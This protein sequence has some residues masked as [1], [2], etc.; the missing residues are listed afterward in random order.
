MLITALLIKLDLHGP[1]LFFHICNGFNG[2][3]FRIVKFRTMHV[4]ED[5]TSFAKRPAPTPG[6]PGSDDGYAV[7]IST[8]CRSSSTC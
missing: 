8:S 4:L 1:A 5:G 7:P 2:R 6:S 3:T